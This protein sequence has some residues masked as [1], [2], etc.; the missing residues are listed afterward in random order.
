MN[1]FIVKNELYCV[2][3]N[4][5]KKLNKNKQLIN[6]YETKEEE[7]D[8]EEKEDLYQSKSTTTSIKNKK[9]CLLDKILED[10]DD[11]EDLLVELDSTCIAYAQSGILNPDEAKIKIKSRVIT[12]Y[13]LNI[14][15]TETNKN[16]LKISH[17]C[18]GT[19]AELPYTL[20]KK[21]YLIFFDN[22][23]VS[24]AN[25]NDVYY[26]FDYMTMPIERLSFDHIYFLKSYFEIFPMR[27]MVNMNKKDM[28][29]V[30]LNNKWHDCVKVEQ[31]DC[32]LVKFDL[33]LKY[34]NH[35][36]TK[37][38]DSNEIQTNVWF[39]RGSPCILPIYDAIMNKITSYNDETVK[40]TLLEKYI[41]E[42][43]DNELNDEKRNYSIKYN[44]YSSTQLPKTASKTII[45][46]SITNSPPKK[47]LK[48][49]EEPTYGKLVNIDLDTI[50]Q[51]KTKDYEY[52]ECNIL[53]IFNLEDEI[54][55]KNDMNPL[56]IPIA[57]GWQRLFCY[58][59]KTKYNCPKKYI[60][61]RAPCGKVL[62]S[63]KE[64]DDFLYLT[65]SKL[66]ID[67]YSFDF[68]IRINVNFKPDLNYIFI[69]DISQGEEFVPISCVNSIDN[70][71]WDTKF[72]TYAKK[73]QQRKQ[74]KDVP[75]NTDPK[76]LEGCNCVDKCRDRSKCSC[77][78]KTFEMTSFDLDEKEMNTNVG[79]RWGR[80]H[81]KVSTGIFECNSKCGCD[82][83]CS[84][85]VVQ[86]GTKVR[87]QLFKTLKKGWGVRSLDDIPKGTFITVYSGDIMNEQQSYIRSNDKCGDKY[88]ADLNFIDCLDLKQKIAQRENLNISFLQTDNQASNTSI[89]ARKSYNSTNKTAEIE[90]IVIDSDEDEQGMLFSSRSSRFQ[91]CIKPILKI[92][93]ENRENYTCILRFTIDA[94]KLLIYC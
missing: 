71:T 34:L 7:E 1:I 18:S 30:Y 9:N 6:E 49:K 35:N 92:L 66:T 88:F 10:D 62:K 76:N 68:S 2:K 24:Y 53:C 42:K 87:L 51:Y 94:F 11:D 31:V 72:F 41:M 40:L 80:L 16:L 39:Y 23:Y 8:E 13:K 82:E 48:T 45:T 79:Y 3:F 59:N 65:D 93:D 63:T 60:N 77:W 32:S 46:S 5:I 78:R 57:H 15:Q 26:I 85:R 89:L 55:T 29:T 17:M 44:C 75:L 27:S 43:N 36:L 12:N 54:S 58:Q 84:N 28:L 21:R 70:E 91:S 38:N 56:L 4:K 64:I 90:Y 86:N 47:D 22:G 83:R 52:H 33:K 37:L 50:I 74:L 25:A 14:I 73:K 81:Q 67:M 61:Y 19:I 69:P 20:N